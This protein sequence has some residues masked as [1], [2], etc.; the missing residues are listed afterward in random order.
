MTT[1]H[2]I[3][4]GCRLVGDR[5]RFMAQR[6]AML[7]VEPGLIKQILF[8]HPDREGLGT[9]TAREG[10]LNKPRQ[11]ILMFLVD[12]GINFFFNTPIYDSPLD[13]RR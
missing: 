10:Y 1:N 11:N 5:H 8:E 6:T 4:N 3:I 9:V 7:G 2:N 13:I 12:Y